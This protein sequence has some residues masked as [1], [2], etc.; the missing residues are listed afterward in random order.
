MLF[1]FPFFFSLTSIKNQGSKRMELINLTLG[2]DY[3]VI[4]EADDGGSSQ[5]RRCYDDLW[6]AACVV[7]AV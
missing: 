6:W 7:V 5:Y 4:R 2:S 3:C 1:T